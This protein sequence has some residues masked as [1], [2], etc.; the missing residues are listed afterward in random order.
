MMKWMMALT[1]LMAAASAHAEPQ[2]GSLD[3]IQQ[4]MN[5][6]E[7][8]KQME[9]AKQQM[10]KHGVDT[11]QLDQQMNRKAA[12]MNLEG[13][14]AFSTCLQEGVGEQGFKRMEGKAVAFEKKLE[15]LCKEGKKDQAQQEAYAYATA[16]KNS[17]DG[18]AVE[19]CRQKHGAKMG[20]EMDDIYKQLGI[21]DKESAHQGICDGY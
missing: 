5:S 21:K 14:I 16:F 9:Q 8:K 6:P 4:M 3:D 13:A 11:S 7:F 15:Q 20:G 19:T 12:G 1:C 17:P 10:Q 18:Q 2:P